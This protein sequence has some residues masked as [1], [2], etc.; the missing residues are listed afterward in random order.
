MSR[1]LNAAKK[2]WLNND[3][4][5]IR[6]I[7]IKLY[8]SELYKIYVKNAKHN[9]DVDE[10]SGFW[11]TD[12]GYEKAVQTWGRDG[13]PLPHFVRKPKRKELDVDKILKMFS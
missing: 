8:N 13:G 6:K 1:E 12:A 9:F 10:K 4:D 3:H 2:I 5:V 7:F 11:K